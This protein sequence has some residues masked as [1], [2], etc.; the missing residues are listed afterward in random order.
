MFP[1]S[2]NRQDCADG[3]CYEGACAGDKV[4][5]TNGD[6]GRTHGFRSCAGIWGDCCNAAGRCGTGEAFCGVGNCQLG[7]CT[8][9]EKPPPKIGGFT[10]D[11]GCGA[12]HNQWKCTEP[13]GKCC[14]KMAAVVVDQ[15]TVAK[16]ASLLLESAMLERS[17]NSSSLKR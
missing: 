6:C 17:N 11:G 5:S 1:W 2:V 9:P 10:E 12:E 4:F 14:G 13:F 8:L 7:N 3:T 16:A 15:P